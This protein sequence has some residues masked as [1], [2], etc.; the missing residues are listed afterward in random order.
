MEL[1]LLASVT[2]TPPGRA[3]LERKT[4]IGVNSPGASLT[5]EASVIPVPPETLTVAVASGTLG[6]PVDAVMVAC[7]EASPV[8]VAVVLEA[9]GWNTAEAEMLATVGLLEVRLTVSPDGGAGLER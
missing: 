2:L 3:G 4:G 1:S 5:P 9:F 8:M 6:K 7:P